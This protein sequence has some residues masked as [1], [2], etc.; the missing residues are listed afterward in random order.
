M[1]DEFI[2]GTGTVYVAPAGTP[3]PSNAT[4][5]LDAAFVPVGL[6]TTDGVRL[7]I[8]RQF[9]R[10]RIWPELQ[11][12]RV[13]LTAQDTQAEWT[14]LE[15]SP[16]TLQVAF[17]GGTVTTTGDGGWTF[18][19]APFNPPVPQ[20]AVVIDMR[21]GD[22]IKRL[23]LDRASIAG[24]IETTFSEDTPALLPIT[25]SVATVDGAPAWQIHTTTVVSGVFVLVGTGPPPADIGSAGDVWL[26]MTTGDL[27]TLV[28]GPP[29][30]SSTFMRDPLWG[31]GPPSDTLG[32]AGDAYIDVASADL[33]VR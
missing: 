31:S 18:T 13:R 9:R 8:D 33:W 23:V 11:A 28:G 7:S 25:V 12:S 14:M 16:T 3:V 10:R 22:R 17:A 2:A 20:I 26:D 30:P 29:P 32:A 1:S 4:D 24:S 27:W 6:T 15:W 5:A 21:D 19:P